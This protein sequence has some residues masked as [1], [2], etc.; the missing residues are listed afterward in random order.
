VTHRRAA[1]IWAT[2]EV[3]RLLEPRAVTQR[4]RGMQKL[5]TGKARNVPQPDT[6]LTSVLDE[7]ASGRVAQESQ[8]SKARH[9]A[10]L[11]RIYEDLDAAL[12]RADSLL[13]QK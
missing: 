5:A 9:E 6:P 12:L 8:A 2:P 11:D 13:G 7:T 10:R 4:I 1:R 3:A